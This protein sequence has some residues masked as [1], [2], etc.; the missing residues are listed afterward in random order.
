MDVEITLCAG[1]VSGYGVCVLCYFRLGVNFSNKSL[2]IIILVFDASNKFQ[3]IVLLE[4]CQKNANQL[5]LIQINKTLKSKINFFWGACHSWWFISGGK[6][7]KIMVAV[8]LNETEEIFS[9]KR[10]HEPSTVR[11]IHSNRFCYLLNFL[12]TILELSV[13]F[14][15]SFEE[16]D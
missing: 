1:W 16:V 6:C 10:K 11:N 3:G 4:W 15:R 13:K 9:L 12:E 5:R 8:K 2:K 7:S 14:F